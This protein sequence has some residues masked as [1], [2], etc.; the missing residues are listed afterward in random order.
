MPGF[1]MPDPQKILLKVLEEHADSSKWVGAKFERIKRISNS[2]VGDIGQAFIERLCRDI[3][4]DIGF[5][6][7]GAKRMR[8][9]PWDIQ[10]QNVKF[11]LKTATEDVGGA[12]QFNHIRY[13]RPY[14][15]L[16]CLGISPSE[17]H[18]DC[19]SKAD[20]TT[21]KAGTLVTMEKGAN[22]SYK[23]TKRPD[24]LRVISEF[25]SHVMDLVKQLGA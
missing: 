19:W 23:L 12:F 20:V 22:A 13:H 8:Q 3:G 15:A 4:I 2:K 10:I 21:G 17:I 14:D 1:Q 24:Q 5:P 25:R 16:L 6:E 7:S 11:E 9:S 18:F